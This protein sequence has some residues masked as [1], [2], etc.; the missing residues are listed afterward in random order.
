[1]VSQAAL[2]DA[3]QLQPLPVDT[4]TLPAAADA[5]TEA[6][7]GEIV[8]E[9]PGDWEIVT[10]W[11]ATTALPERDGPV[12]AA[13]VTNTEAD[14]LPDAGES[15]SHDTLL[16]AVQGQD[17]GAVIAMAVVVPDGPAA[18]DAWSIANV[19]PSDWMMLNFC[20]ETLMVALRGGPVELRTSKLKTP[21][22]CPDPLRICTHSA[23]AAADHEHM[24]LEAR[25]CTWPDPPDW[26][27]LAELC[28]SDS[29]H[30]PAAWLTSAR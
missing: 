7:S 26:L 30:S 5:A 16:D 1:M 13:T 6:L 28:A 25:T 20:P 29:S 17:A 8:N 24:L 21:L 19:Q 10:G 27:K 3:V 22:P 14:P 18:S 11:P 15:E 12:V 4:D 9:H 23:S 2:L